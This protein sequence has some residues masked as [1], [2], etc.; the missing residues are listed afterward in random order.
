[1]NLDSISTSKES[2]PILLGLNQLSKKNI[3]IFPTDKEANEF[4]SNFSN[5]N[6]NIEIFQIWWGCSAEL[7]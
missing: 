7:R 2:L 5:L 6:E 3:Y 1:M 4:K